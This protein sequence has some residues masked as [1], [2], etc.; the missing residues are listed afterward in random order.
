VI[1]EEC[2]SLN[3]AHFKYMATGLPLVTLKFA[4]TVD[5]RIATTTGSSQ[6]ISSEKFQKL[7]HRLRAANDAVMVGAGTVLADDPQ[8]TVRAV[9]GRNPL[10]I[11]LDSGLSIPL[12]ARV[13]KNQ[14]T[15]PTIIATT[16]R[17]DKSKLSRLRQMGIEVLAVAD[18]EGK[19]DLKELLSAL[20]KRG[21]SSILVEGGG[22]VITSLLRQ[23]LADKLV[24]AIALKIMGKGIEAV[25]ELGITDVNKSLK[26][27]FARVYRAG[28]DIVVEA[29]VKAE[30]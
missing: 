5:G 16:P 29:R 27:S 6:W 12:D 11:V 3:E 21:I 7:A 18:D 10:R 14:E 23:G 17:A 2:R 22:S 30:R 1:E 26:L 24:I 9:K 4:Q 15:A 8:L 20:G 28:E 25:G 19:V 13:L